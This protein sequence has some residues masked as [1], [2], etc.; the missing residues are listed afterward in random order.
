V[1]Y[2]QIASIFGG[3]T[4]AAM[5]IAPVKAA[6]IY[7]VKSGVTSV[8]H[9]LPE[10]STIGINLSNPQQTI[11][12]VT[13]NFLLGFKIAPTSNFKFSD[14]NGFT[15]IAGTIEHFGT[16]LFNSNTTIGNFSIGYD[17]TRAV[18]GVSGFFLKDTVSTNTVLF[19]LS[20]PANSVAFNGKNLRITDV[21]LLISP[22]LAGILNNPSLVGRLGGNARLDA[23]VAAVPEPGSLLAIVLA[24]AALMANKR[25]SGYR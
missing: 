8:Y 12:P 14:A 15:P 1:R 21:N 4:L 24:G 18:N 9:D 19:D 6:T 13:D 5:T 10:L 22:E 16:V 17:P 23:D 2:S 11:P 7:Q 25:L 3:L 20:I